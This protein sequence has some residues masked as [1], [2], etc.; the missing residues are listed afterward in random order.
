VRSQQNPTR[1]GSGR[2][3]RELIVARSRY[4]PNYTNL[5]H[6]TLGL[7]SVYMVLEDSN[8]NLY[9]RENLKCYVKLSLH[10]RSYALTKHCVVDC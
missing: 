3:A 5:L 10:V 1:G 8:L 2:A 9:H 7:P 4:R 6:Y